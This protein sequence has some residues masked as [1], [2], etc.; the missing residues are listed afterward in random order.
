MYNGSQVSHR[1]PLGYLFCVLGI[2]AKVMAGFS[3]KTTY[4]FILK[5]FPC[6]TEGLL[7]NNGSYETERITE[8]KVM[9]GSVRCIKA[10]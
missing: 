6:E 8:S 3:L 9:S 10:F 7:V 4:F 2:S 5:L 1:C